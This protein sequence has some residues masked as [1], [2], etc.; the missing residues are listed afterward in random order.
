[1]S[2]ESVLLEESRGPL[3]SPSWNPEGQALA[4]G[5]LVPEEEGRGRLEIVIQEA[6]DR[7]RVVLARPVNE[8]HARAADLPGLSLALSPARGYLAG[9]L[10]LQTLA[11]GIVRA[12]NGRV[13]KI[14]DDAYFPAWSPDGT[15]LAFV[16]GHGNGA[17]SLHY[18]DHNFGP[19]RHLLDIG[20]T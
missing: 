7:K 20:Q 4:F 5:R 8:F 13:L 1:A 6:P 17:E 19:S 16:Q 9:P 3:T 10:P 14:I 18:V 15:K 12:D 2:R 11:L